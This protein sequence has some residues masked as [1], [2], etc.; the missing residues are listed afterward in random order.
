MEGRRGFGE[1]GD[2][3][4]SRADGGSYTQGK[5]RRAGFV[6]HGS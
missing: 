4:M 2:E 3:K 5:D 1:G 6:L